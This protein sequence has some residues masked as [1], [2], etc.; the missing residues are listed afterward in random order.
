MR[1]FGFAGLLLAICSSQALAQSFFDP[2]VAK[3]VDL[4]KEFELAEDDGP[5]LVKVSSFAGDSARRSAIN[6]TR[7]LR[8]ELEVDAYA[9]RYKA[10]PTGRPS[11]EEIKK[12]KRQFEKRFD[13]KPR[14]GTLNTPP[15]ENWVVLAGNFEEFNDRTAKRILKKIRKLD[16]EDLPKGV[17]MTRFIT[18]RSQ[19]DH[20]FKTAH[21][22]RNPLAKNDQGEGIEKGKARMLLAMNQGEMSAYQIPD[23]FTISVRQF[24]GISVVGDERADEVF[25]KGPLLSSKRTGLQIAGE[26]A[27]NLTQLLRNMGYDAYVFHGEYASIVCIGGYSHPNDPRLKGDLNKFVNLRVGELPLLPKVIPT[28][29]QPTMRAN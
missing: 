2:A 3:V 9:F 6:L 5:V 21:L 15:Q 28:P 12:F 14:L 13:I 7:Y 20:P 27:T 17:V 10:N 23:P 1:F 16:L 11:D 8:E 22:V 24:R 25:R 26:N 19:I 18:D 4:P 29:R